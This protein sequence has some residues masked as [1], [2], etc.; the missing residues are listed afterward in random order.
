MM[1]LG[2]AKQ[3]RDGKICFLADCLHFVE[4]EKCVLA[5]EMHFV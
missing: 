1:L 5:E 4:R 3:T 2:A